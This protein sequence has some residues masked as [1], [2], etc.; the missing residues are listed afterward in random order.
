[1]HFFTLK[2]TKIQPGSTNNAQ[3]NP[4]KTSKPNKMP[5]LGLGLWKI[6]QAQT[7]A[8]IVTALEL[9][10]RHIDSACDYANEPQAGEGIAQAI[11][12][13]ICTRDDLW[14]TS[15]LWNTFHR[16]EHVR[17]ALLKTLSDLKL[18]KLNLFLI[19]FP[20]ALKYVD[21]AT[22]YPPEWLHKPEA[23]KPTMVIDRVPL[24]ETWAAMEALVEEGLVDHIGVSNYNSGLVNDLLN[25]ATIHPAVLQIESH[26]YLTQDKVLQLCDQESIVP[27][28][29]SPLGGSSYVEM[30]MATAEE[31]LLKHPLIHVL[32]SEYT[33]TPAQ[34]LLRWAIQRGT[35][36]ISKSTQKAHLEENFKLFSFELQ[37]KDMQAISGL[38]LNKRYNDPGIFCQAA[39]NTFHTIYD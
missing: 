33:V 2:S 12:Q 17:P 36:V 35:A 27:T 1:M 26:P 6:P 15:K 34:I 21:F 4:Q 16:P 24:H 7:A 5:A 19:H 29:Y 30:D 25:Y 3:N 13:G 9:G 22:R 37:H 23:N 20:I 28:A 32:A 39:F 31:S 10:Y 18:E 8:T 14:V 38:N 11:Q